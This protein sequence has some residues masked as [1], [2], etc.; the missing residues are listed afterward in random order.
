MTNSVKKWPYRLECERFVSPRN[1]DT[2]GLVTNLVVI[3]FYIFYSYKALI[4]IFQ[5]VRSFDL[6]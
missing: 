4:K 6:G 1:P 3:Y 2:S 5:V